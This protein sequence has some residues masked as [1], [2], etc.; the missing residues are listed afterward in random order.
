MSDTGIGKRVVRREDVRFITG[1]GR[2]TDDINL[3][4]QTFAVFLRSPYARARIRSVDASAARAIPG[5]VAVYTGK[6]LAADKVGDLPCGWLVKSK[7]GTDMK[8]AS[9]PPVAVELVN[10]V[11]EPYGL[12]IA[13]TLAA[14]KA[15]AEAVAA[16][17]E[18]LEATVSLAS[19]TE[20]AQIHANVEK[21]ICFDW[22]L[23]DAAATDA[24]FARA[25]HVTRLE[26]A[27]NRLIPNAMEPRAALATYE[28]AT[29]D[30][31]LYTTSQNPHL[32]RLILSAFVGIAP[33]HRI[34]VVS[35]DVGGGFG[36][37]IFVYPEETAV[38]WATR[39]VGRPVKW[40]AER[41]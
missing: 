36:S 13:E 29:G 21:N 6:D 9:R 35:P 17:F 22:E 19:A 18:E 41:S 23:G 16:D 28:A 8:V 40:T 30:F 27:N 32:H 7:D 11:G 25:A 31:T 26:F 20:G 1:Q 24:A 33:E 38:I 12:V 2:Y 5:V 14:A 39:K 37:K 34:R 4:G 15:G 3:P 10:F